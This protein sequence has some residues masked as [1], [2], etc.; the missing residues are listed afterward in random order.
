VSDYDLVLDM[1]DVIRNFHMNLK[2]GDSEWRAVEYILGELTD[3]ENVLTADAVDWFEGMTETCS[4]YLRSDN[5]GEAE[6]L[7]G[8]VESA[9]DV[10]RR[11]HRRVQVEL[12]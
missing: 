12:Q 3:G 8:A 9:I 6:K 1:E 7:L 5:P 4:H 11:Y 10:K 2:F